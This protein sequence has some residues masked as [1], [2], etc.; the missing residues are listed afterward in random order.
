[1]AD[2]SLPSVASSNL[3]P[4]DLPTWA[5][6]QV[7]VQATSNEV[8]ILGS[9]T[10]PATTPEGVPSPFARLRPIVML[11]MSPQ[12]MKDLSIVLTDTV[13]K[14]EAMY[15]QMTTDFSKTQQK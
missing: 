13:K 4:L 7:T 6:S 11:R 15:G 14:Y 3:Q 2:T 9:D 10:V 8:M 12:T 1:M 5:V